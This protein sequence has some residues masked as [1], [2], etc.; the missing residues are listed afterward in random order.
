LLS[1]EYFRRSYYW[2]RGWSDRVRETKQMD[3]R[4]RRDKLILE[5]QIPGG[6]KGLSELS[7]EQLREKIML[8][9]RARE[10]MELASDQLEREQ[11]LREE[12]RR[13]VETR[14]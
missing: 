7:N 8:V 11:G 14:N 13:R 3:R 10:F 2:D 12:L 6:M 1:E 4:C 5:A 9:N